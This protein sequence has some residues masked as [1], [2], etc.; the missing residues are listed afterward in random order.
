MKSFWRLAIYI[1]L[2]L[3]VASIFFFAL[4]PLTGLPMPPMLGPVSTIFVWGF[5]L[6]HAG[7]RLGWRNALVF[8]SLAFGVGLAL[9]AVGVATGWIYGGYHYSSRLGPQLLGVPVLIPM[10]WFMVIY[11]A[12]SLSERLAGPWAQARAPGRVLVNVLLGAVVA[13]AWDV[14]AD[15]QMAKSKLWIWDQPGAFFGVPVQNF[16]GWLATAG[17]VLG[18]YAALSRRWPPRSVG[19]NSGWFD[20]LPVLAYGALALS[21]VLGYAAQGEAALAV[22]AFFTMG[23]LALAALASPQTAGQSPQSGF[24]AD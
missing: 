9:E 3:Y 7:W 2:G 13:T 21:F 20:Q 23:A 6:L 10:S 15:P 11:L 16:A 22:I 18:L 1:L 17:L 8:F 12:Y 5:A 19:E 14:V 24:R 4:K